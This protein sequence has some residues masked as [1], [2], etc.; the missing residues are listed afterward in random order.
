VLLN[1]EGIIRQL[2]SYCFAVVSPPAGS[3]AGGG[4]QGKLAGRD[5]I[6][7]AQLESEQ[8]LHVDLARKPSPNRQ[9]ALHAL[10]QDTYPEWAFTA[11]RSRALGQASLP[12]GPGATPTTGQQCH[13]SSVDSAGKPL[14]G[15]IASIE[16]YSNYPQTAAE[17]QAQIDQKLIVN[18]D[19]LPSSK[20]AKVSV[21][22]H[23]QSIP[24]FYQ[25]D[26]YYTAAQA[27]ETP[28]VAPRR[29]HY[30]AARPKLD[31]THVKDSSLVVSETESTVGEADQGDC[32]EMS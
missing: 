28:I 32:Q 4:S 14:L 22:L 13:M 8:V 6:L 20:P 27:Q 29:L 23:C 17:N 15:K 11:Y 24:P 7:S 2:A 3:L 26:R 10:I 5:P 31:D 9:Q 30:L 19:G 21:R 25:Q 18:R 1:G 12:S 16:E